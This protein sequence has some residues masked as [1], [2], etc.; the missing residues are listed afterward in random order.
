[1]R[2]PHPLPH[3]HNAFTTG[4]YYAKRTER[5]D[6]PSSD[7]FTSLQRERVDNDDALE[8]WNSMFFDVI[9]N[10]LPLK[11][12]RVKSSPAPWLSSEIKKEMLKRDFLLRLAVRTN[13]TSDWD[14]A[15]QPRCWRGLN[16]LTFQR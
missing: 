8:L 11:S 13:V 15:A 9:N 3:T 2:P 5:V 14:L 7:L 6:V 10:H 12:K 4:A 1:M 16:T